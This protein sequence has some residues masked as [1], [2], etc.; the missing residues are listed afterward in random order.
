[1]NTR[2]L[3]PE[4]LRGRRWRGLVRESTDAQAEMWSPSRQR[5]DMERAAEELGLVASAPT[6]YERVGSGEDEHVDELVQA[7][8]D[9]KAGRYDVLL[10]FHTSRFARNVEESRRVKRLARAQGLVIYFVAQRIISGSRQARLLEGISEVIDEEANEERRHW[11]AGG[12]REKQLAG[13]WH[14]TVPYGY[15]RHM[16]DRPDG[17]RGPDGRL[18]PDPVESPVVRHIFEEA[19]SGRTLRAISRGLNADG[20]RTRTGLFT[21]RYIGDI[22]ANPAYAGLLVRYRQPAADLYYPVTDPYDGRREIAGDWP[23]L[24]EGDVFDKVRQ[25]VA[26]RIP[27]RGASTSKA[28]PLSGVLRCLCGRPMTGVYRSPTRYYRCAGRVEKLCGE[29]YVRADVAEGAMSSW[30]GGYR[31]PT[32]WRRLIVDNA[33]RAHRIDTQQRREAL[34]AQLVRLRTMFQY[35]DIPEAEYRAEVDAVKGQIAETV[36]P[37]PERI[38]A[39]ADAFTKIGAAWA[40]TPAPQQ[41]AFAT[42]LLT[43]AVA[44]QDGFEWVVRPE[45]R[46]LLEMLEERRADRVVGD[47]R[48]YSPERKYTLRFSA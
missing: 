20:R 19:L 10:V 6:W 44:H 18:E 3:R 21:V 29:P 45:L 16:V 43:R 8:A 35:G 5:A 36:T 13:R 1:M 17:S 26:E 28:Y 9:A 48:L 23:A 2:H 33:Q 12:I 40:R 37:A 22:L 39:V 24:I 38:E 31:L 4:D 14:G 34:T 30:L 25:M 47:G 32:N 11:I 7:L 41:R 46:P 27:S 42:A 15:R